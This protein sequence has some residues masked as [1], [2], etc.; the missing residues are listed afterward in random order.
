M[1]GEHTHLPRKNQ[2]PQLKKHTGAASSAPEPRG[3]PYDIV[4]LQ[5][6][7]GNQALQRLI[8]KGEL[9]LQREFT[10]N[11]LQPQQPNG[12]YQPIVPRLNNAWGNNANAQ[13]VETW[14]KTHSATVAT[15][16]S[17]FILMRQIRE[18][19]P[20][21][22]A[23]DTNYLMA[24]VRQWI[25]DNQVPV[26]F[27]LND[28]PQTKPL[29]PEQVKEAGES[30]LSVS[31]S[32]TISGG[33]GVL[34]LS[35]SGVTGELKQKAGSHSDSVTIKPD[36]MSQKFKHGATTVSSGVTWKG[37]FSFEISHGIYHF[38]G[39]V[40]PTQWKLTMRLGEASSPDAKAIAEVF[41]KA[42][43]ALIAGIRSTANATKLDEV[44]AG[45]TDHMGDVKK[46]VTTVEESAKAGTSARFSINIE[47]FAPTVG[48][49]GAAGPGVGIVGQF[50]F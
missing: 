34:T 4:Q 28:Q 1:S 7:I 2:Q 30:G 42:E 40:S 29:T 35:S 37:D 41:R 46:A 36:G 10:F 49:A 14:L 47:V 12:H 18:K 9:P 8:A 20:E 19:V 13:A 45:I 6:L 31:T 50:E 5:R 11:P 43:S 3:Q 15:V 17:M 39:S 27:S 21:A 25:S 48:A 44:K 23:F 26:Q 32:T 33:E 22:S 16:S 24:I 38:S